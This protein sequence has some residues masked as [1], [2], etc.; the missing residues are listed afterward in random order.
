MLKMTDRDKDIISFLRQYKCADTHTIA[1]LFF[2]DAKS[3]QI[4]AERRM[5]KLSEFGKCNRWRKDI[6][7]PYIFYIGS[8]PTNYNHSCYISEVYANLMNK[9]EVVKI[10]REYE[11]KFN[12]YKVRSDLMAVVRINGKLVPLLIEVDLSS[13]MKDKYDLFINDNYYQQKFPMKPIVISISRFTPKSSLSIKHIT[14]EEFK[15]KGIIIK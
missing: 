11:L 12:K 8:R 9:Y 10:E 13:A 4:L 3:S 14:L 2:S 7:S 5:K 15:E 1:K 6:L